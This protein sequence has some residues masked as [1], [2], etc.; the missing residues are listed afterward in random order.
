[1]KFGIGIMLVAFGVWLTHNYPA[2]A[3]YILDYTIK[4]IDWV[5][6]MAQMAVES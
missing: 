6:Y 3:S 1:M 5:A 2:T 4:A